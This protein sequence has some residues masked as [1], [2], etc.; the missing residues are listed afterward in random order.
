[1]C[2]IIK[3]NNSYVIDQI[4]NETYNIRRY[5]YYLHFHILYLKKNRKCIGYSFSSF[6]VFLLNIDPMLL[7]SRN[8][9]N[10]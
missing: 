5:N 10:A 6:F 2:L 7:F 1:M 3:Y 8:Q 4:Y 9:L